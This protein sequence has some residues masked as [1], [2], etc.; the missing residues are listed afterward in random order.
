VSPRRLRPL[1]F[2]LVAAGVWSMSPGC[3]G[4]S[5]APAPQK[6]P[7]AAPAASP[8][9]L[10][11]A[12]YLKRSGKQVALVV[13]I[14]DY[15][16]R[17]QI[18]PTHCGAANARA[19]AKALTDRFGFE[20]EELT[21]A[22]ASRAG[23]LERLERLG[24]E[25]GGDDVLLVYFAG[26]GKI[27]ELPDGGRFGYLLPHD[28]ELD[29]NEETSPSR[30]RSLSPTDTDEL[31]KRWD[32]RAIDM[33]EIVRRLGSVK[34]Q[35]VVVI[36]DACFSGF[37]THLGPE[38]VYPARPD[39]EELL[40]RRSRTVLAA[41]TDNNLA[42]GPRKDEPHSIFTSELLK[43]LDVN[44]PAALTEVFLDVR[45]NVA[46][47]SRSQPERFRMLPQ[48]GEFGGDGGEFIFV[49]T[50]VP[51]AQLM[52]GVGGSLMRVNGQLPGLTTAAD[53]FRAFAVTDYHFGSRPLERDREWQDRVGRYEVTAAFG[54]PLSMAALHYCY[55][56]GLGVPKDD[57]EAYRWAAKAFDTGRPEG[58]HVMGRCLLQGIGT[59]KNPVAAE[60]LIRAAAEGG[61]AL[62][63]YTLAM[64]RLAQDQASAKPLLEKAAAAGVAPAKTRLAILL[65]NPAPGAQRDLDS[66]ERLL[67]EAADAGEA[68]ANFHLFE[69]N[70]RGLGDRP[71]DLE[72]ARKA[73]TR[74]AEDGDPLCQ[75]ALACEYDPIPDMPHYGWSTRLSL[76][77]D[78][79]E[80]VKWAEL[81]ASAGFNPA[82]VYLA[83]TYQGGEDRPANPDKARRYC[84]LAAN[85]GYAPAVVRQGLW[86]RDGIVYDRD[87]KKAL[88]SFNRAAAMGDYMAYTHL[89]A[90][91]AEAR[92]VDLHGNPPRLMIPVFEFHR[93][94]C[95][96]RAATL[97]KQQGLPP[98]QAE[99][100]LREIAP[101]I[102]HDT[103]N[104]LQ[105]RY[106]ESYKILIDE[107][108]VRH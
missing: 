64:Q 2:A 45:K 96:V 61:F 46:A 68:S 65:L 38:L 105:A 104:E 23:I 62:S 33:K 103:L 107:Y 43:R 31:L 56:R 52:A 53:V 27:I 87:D 89:A 72:R 75:L 59:E 14:D 99:R 18:E 81:A 73:L 40:R 82:R 15:K 11:K 4:R 108:G 29:L 9:S 20:S 1:V 93:I 78:P 49:P 100:T 26:H 79:T 13:G 63:S 17:Q 42:L 41:T 5:P 101:R 47:E 12:Y 39:L 54:D 57:G 10:Q 71:K 90:M 35:H 16:F 88:A 44:E 67:T 55:A 51:A 98:S 32:E 86:Y 92:G 66:A 25:L 58:K 48:R 95:L 76:R 30:L 28:A 102:Q 21:E 85:D 22:E 6:T 50:K 69:I 83:A 91:F 77:R 80:A 74:G 36:V 7:A 37:M 34:A 70:A 94:H 60:R 19:M 3:G 106:P 24:K 8:T 97:A 84:E